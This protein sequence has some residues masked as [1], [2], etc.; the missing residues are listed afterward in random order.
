MVQFGKSWKNV[1]GKNQTKIN[2]NQPQAH[3]HTQKYKM[4]NIL[5]ARGIGQPDL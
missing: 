4:K 5:C 2:K 3:T 1:K